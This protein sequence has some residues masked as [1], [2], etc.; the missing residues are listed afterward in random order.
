M[1]V[2]DL[3]TRNFELLNPSL[4]DEKW[5]QGTGKGIEIAIIDSG[6]ET[7]HPAL[8]GKIVDSVEAILE[9]DKIVFRPSDGT[10]ATGHGTACASI[11]AS[12]APEAKLHSIKILGQANDARFLLAALDYAIQKRFQIVNLSLGTTK[13]H[14]YVPLRELLDRAY[15]TRTIIVAAANNL[16]HPSYPSIFCSSLISVRKSE[17]TDPF[18]FGFHYGEAI[19]LTAP[20]VNVQTAWLNGT[21]KRLTGNSFA[22][23]HI[24]GIVALLLE[25]YPQLTPFQ[26]KSLLYS[27]ARK[28]QQKS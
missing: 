20:G 17:E 5:K 10:D 3:N 18:K 8:Q 13:T 14:Y 12:I 24:V 26:V 9:N 15:Q 28:N 7:S 19:E 2:T 21:Y 1:V 16:P 27:L 22:C 6:V 23:P 4:L 25:K 11:I